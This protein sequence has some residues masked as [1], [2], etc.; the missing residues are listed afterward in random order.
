MLQGKNPPTSIPNSPSLLDRRVCRGRE[1][2]RKELGMVVGWGLVGEGIEAA[3]IIDFMAL[4]PGWEAGVGL[5][6]A[7]SGLRDHS[8][9]AA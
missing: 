4:P 3:S 7:R 9:R 1:R 2:G 5:Q 8:E 6:P